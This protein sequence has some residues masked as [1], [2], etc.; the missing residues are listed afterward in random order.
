MLKTECTGGLGAWPW[1][2]GMAKELFVPGGTLPMINTYLQ[3]PAASHHILSSLSLEF[4]PACLYPYKFLNQILTI[5]TE[6]YT[7]LGPEDSHTKLYNLNFRFVRYWLIG[8]YVIFIIRSR[9]LRT[10][11]EPSL[12]SGF[13]IKSFSLLN[14]II[15][16]CLTNII[17][18][19][20]LM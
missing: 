11:I 6:S 18:L 4:V 14:H 12:C 17:T 8:L 13:Y 16:Q 2:P 5:Y 1:E 3:A 15:K 10:L 19:S 20:I 7:S 9:D